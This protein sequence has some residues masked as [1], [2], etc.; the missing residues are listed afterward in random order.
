MDEFICSEKKVAENDNYV[1]LE[2]NG[3]DAEELADDFGSL[4]TIFPEY[5]FNH[6]KLY[7][8]EDKQFYLD[9]DC[10]EFD[11]FDIDENGQ[12]VKF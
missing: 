10:D 12:L 11:S 6:N 7:H 5:Q 3:L 2:L 8:C 1:L 4:E 9:E